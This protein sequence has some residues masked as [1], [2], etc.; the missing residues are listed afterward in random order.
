[1]AELAPEGTS[2][3]RMQGYAYAF[4]ANARRVA[5][6]L[7]AADRTFTLAWRLWRAAGP[8]DEGILGEWRLLDL[9]ASLRRAQL[10]LAEALSLLDQALLAAPVD[11]RGRILLNKAITLEQAGEI[12]A[13]VAVLEQAAP[14]VDAGVEL[15]DRMIL[16]FNGLV[17]LC[18]LG[19]YREA[20]G[21]LAELQRLVHVLGAP[22]DSIRFRWLSSRVAAGMGRREEAL[23]GFLA[24][25]TEFQER[26]NAYDTA[27]V[28][29]E[30]A[31]LYLQD[32]RTRDVAS[33]V[34]QMVWIF[35]S[36][37]IHREALAALKIFRQAAQREMATVDL[38]RRL[39]D[40]L[41]R[42]RNDPQP[43]RA[44]RRTPSGK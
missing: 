35:R 8:A 6:D 37:G 14:L 17:M 44:A 39:R 1:V 4:L 42:S 34:K 23:A 21:S 24:V 32:G 12:S 19:R 13:G 9:E 10:R 5:G 29:L 30:I 41:D 38:T 20:D 31:I 43:F 3:Q 27:L 7:A 15:R 40:Y 22:E 25:R 36:Q 16:R 33:L 28:S 2:F 26:A 18:H 11:K